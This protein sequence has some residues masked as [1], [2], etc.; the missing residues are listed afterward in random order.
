VHPFVLGA[1]S[2][3]GFGIQ[4]LYLP[5]ALAFL[6]YLLFKS[7][8]KLTTFLAFFVGAVIGNLPMVLFDLRNN[9]YHLATLVQYFVDTLNGISDASFNYYYLLPL[10]SILSLVVGWF[11]YNLYRKSKLVAIVLSVSYIVLNLNSSLIDF[12]KPIGMA[13]GL[14]WKEIR[15]A[16]EVIADDRPRDFNVAVLLDF[17]TRGYILRYPIEYIHGFKPLGE[18]MYREAGAIYVLSRTDYN[19]RNPKV[20]EL[21][22]AYPYDIQ[23]LSEIGTHYGVYKIIK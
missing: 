22:V 2:G 4:F 9:F 16:A 10:W 5:Y 3:V 11:F 15:R 13:D 21:Q 7:H 23:I 19:Y 12:E 8:R 18:E 17:D 14:T 1:V 20:W 6:V